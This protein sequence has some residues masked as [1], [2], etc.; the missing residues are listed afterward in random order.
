MLT[1]NIRE[2][3]ASK[4]KDPAKQREEESTRILDALKKLDG[5]VWILDEEGERM[6]SHEF[7]FLLEQARDAGRPLIFVLGGAYGLTPEVK[8]RGNGRLRISDMTLP[9][10]L[11]RV[12]F[13]EQLYR[14][15][16]ILRGSG[17][18]H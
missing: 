15:C 1:L 13:L 11:C 7:S 6:K 12:L 3:P 17:Y 4:Q 16:E 14:G 18:H 9:H 5:D 8:K 2:L 10:E